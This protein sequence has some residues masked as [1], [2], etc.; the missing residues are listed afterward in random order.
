MITFE[1]ISF[2]NILS[3]GN[4]WTTID[5]LSSE[6]FLVKGINGSG[7]SAGILDTLCFGLFGKPFRKINKPN[8]VNY[9]NRKDL[10]V[11]LWFSNESHSYLITRGLNPQILEIYRDGKFIDQ[12][13]SIKDFQNFF[14]TTILGM[15]YNSFTQIVVLGKATYQAFFRLQLFE[16]RKFIENI[17]NLSVFAV[18]GD[19]NKIKIIE[20]KNSLSTVKT[21]LII[22]KEKIQLKER[23]IN[24]LKKES[25]HQKDEFKRHRKQQ[26]FIYKKEIK[27]CEEKI[28]HLKSKF[29]KVKQD[30][31]SLNKKKD[32]LLKFQ[33]G[34]KD[35]IKSIES[36][37]KFFSDN[38]TCPTCGSEINECSKRS[39]LD[40]LFIKKFSFITAELEIDDKIKS[41]SLIIEE[42]KETIELN[43]SFQ[44]E[45]E[46]TEIDI[47]HKIILIEQFN[48]DGI[49]N[50]EYHNSFEEDINKEIGELKELKNFNE[51]KLKD[52]SNILNDIEYFEF[53]SGMLKDS[54]IK[55]VIIK[56]YIPTIIKIMNGY[57]N[58][59]GLFVRFDLNENFEES[60]FSRGINSLNYHAFSEGEKLRIDLAMLMTWREICRLQNNLDVNLLI[61]DEILDASLDESGSEDL[62][63]LFSQLINSKIKVVVISHSNDKWE[64]Y[65]SKIITFEK[66]SGFSRIIENNA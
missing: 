51:L 24:T 8:L 65:F 28:I 14:E 3:F 48:N 46:S 19:L 54:G 66:K 5:F 33:S 9:K 4:D 12:N 34:L 36:K 39:K 49:N 16:R 55:S 27:E 37:I 17:L 52:K 30:L 64:E 50:S 31:N 6:N 53:I 20:L 62:I 40:E 21:E 35:K 47:K 42:V 63:D 58:N 38:N 29:K 22:L 13:P 45:I 41:V 10:V 11:K 59:L 23:H 56:R 18:M 43:S 2:K 25:Q 15:D 32:I 60:F 44:R 57:L 7:K 61:F 1:K 26:V